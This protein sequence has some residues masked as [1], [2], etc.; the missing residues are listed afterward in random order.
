MNPAG[1]KRIKAVVF[2]MDGVLIDAKEWHYEA[3][4]KALGLF[5]Y[6]INRYDHLTTF[7]GLP[8][9]RKLEMLSVDRGLPRELHEFIGEMKQAYTMDLVHAR[10]RPSF[11]HEFALSRLKAAGYKLAVASNSVRSTVDL[12]MQRAG[13]SGYLDARLSNQDVAQ[14]KPHP[15]IYLAAMERLEVAAR[16]CLVVEDNDHGVRAARAAGAEVL[17]VADVHETNLENILRAIATA[18][19]TAA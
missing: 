17:V 16:E 8:T 14:P 1:T 19:G 12:M 7:D 3:L 4:N 15:E 9:S 18:E 11:V 13:L 10:C 6:E 5:G 2:D